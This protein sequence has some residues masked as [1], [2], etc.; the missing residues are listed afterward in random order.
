MAK[1]SINVQFHEEMRSRT[2]HVTDQ[3]T[4]EEV[5]QKILRD[6]DSR[7]AELSRDM[8]FQ[9]FL[10]RP[11]SRRETEA[12]ADMM[13]NGEFLVLVPT[14]ERRVRPLELSCPEY[15]WQTL[16]TQ[17]DIVVG[18]ADPELNRQVVL[19]FLPD[20]IQ[21]KIS[22]RQFIVRYQD[23]E[24]YLLKHDK[25]RV[26]VFINGHVLN[27]PH[28]LRTG[29]QIVIGH[30]LETPYLTLGARISASPH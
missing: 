25:A 26:P 16:I 22:R 19:D 5:T 4:V 20:S 23:T 10:C 17:P 18:R 29:D 12:L 28:L 8:Q 15:A 9:L 14:G 30:A 2:I 27:G 7:P 6:M 24:W 1:I 13:K 21:D 11:I 3:M